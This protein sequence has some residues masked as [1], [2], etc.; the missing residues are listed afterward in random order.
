LEELKDFGATC[1]K[2]VFGIPVVVVDDAVVVILQ[3]N[4]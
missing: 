4:N 2:K 3:V 1:T